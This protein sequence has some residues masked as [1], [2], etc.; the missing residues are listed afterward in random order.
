MAVSGPPKRKEEAIINKVDEKA[1]S[2]IINSGGKTISENISK[3]IKIEKDGLGALSKNRA[4]GLKG[5]TLLLTIEEAE[6]INKLRQS[7]IAPRGK[8]IA[9]SFH[10]W[11]VEAI[12]DKIQKE[13]KNYKVNF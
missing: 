3:T 12:H 9:I 6:T 5:I 1:I 13:S 7:R 11:I 8:K 4:K 10:D 2:D